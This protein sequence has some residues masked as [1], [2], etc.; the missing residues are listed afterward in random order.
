MPLSRVWERMKCDDACA[1]LSADDLQ[2]GLNVW[3]FSSFALPSRMCCGAWGARSWTRARLILGSN[4]TDNHMRDRRC[5]RR[6][7]C[8]LL[9]HNSCQR[10][11][12]TEISASGFRRGIKSLMEGAVQQRK[13]EAL[14]LF[15]RDLGLHLDSRG[16][17]SS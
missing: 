2:Q 3:K 7:H 1:V 12:A 10:R 9:S 17:L 13:G 6:L 4:H 8:E 14:S 5:S 15:C 11:N 16:A